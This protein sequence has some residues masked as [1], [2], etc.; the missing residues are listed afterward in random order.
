MS[1]EVKNKISIANTGKKRSEKTKKKISELKKG[2][3]TWMKGKKHTK[4]TLKKMSESHKGKVT[5]IKGKHH[6]NETKDKISLKK[7][8]IN[9]SEEHKRKISASHKG[10]KMSEESKKKMSIAKRIRPVSNETKLK[11]SNIN[12]GKHLS[13]KTKKKI[14]IAFRGYKHP[15]WLGGISKLPYSFDWNEELKMLIRKRDNFTCR[16]CGIPAGIV[17]HIDYD[18]MN[19]NPNNLI[20]L[21]ESC[22]PKTNKDRKRWFWF[23]YRFNLIGGELK[24]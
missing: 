11:L 20:T 4:E 3:I 16:L 21:C 1:K 6:S 2:K 23:F 8:G 9:I 19:S 22:H 12:K 10:K 17:H 24:W 5:W 15:L 18:K 14:S 7:K 13:E